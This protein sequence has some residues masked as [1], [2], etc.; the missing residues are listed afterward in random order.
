M[1]LVTGATVG[2]IATNPGLIGL[3]GTAGANAMGAAIIPTVGAAAAAEGAAVGTGA[4]TV[5][6]LGEGACVAAG[7]LAGGS[8]SAGIALATAA[9]PLGWAIVGCSKNNCHNS[10]SS[11]TWD[12]WKPV[13]QDT[14]TQPSH[15]MALRDLVTHRNVQS[16]SLDQEGLFVENIFGERFRL[17]PV[18]V[19]GTLAFHASIVVS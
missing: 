17:T 7:T 13:V 3:F 10:D 2:A 11:Y 18:S 4:A 9:G 5:L 15:G 1:V 19:E 14:S 16:M 8:G 12:C 6:A